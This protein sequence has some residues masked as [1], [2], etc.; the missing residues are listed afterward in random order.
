MGWNWLTAL[1]LWGC[2]P[3]RAPADAP[4]VLL[5]TVDT[6]RA[7]HVGAYG[8][9]LALTPNLD[10]LSAGGS[11]FLR[12][13][14]SSPLTIPSH[15]TIFTGRY[16][17]GHGVRD[18]GGFALSDDQVTLAERFHDAGYHTA[19]VTS[20]F[21]TRSRWG[22]GQ[23]FATYHEPTSAAEGGAD[24]RRADEVVDDA[25][26]LVAT[27]DPSRPMFLWVHL[28]DP[29]FPYDPPEQ[30]QRRLP[31]RPYDAEVAFVDAEIGRL[32]VG[33]ESRF[34][35][36]SSVVAVTA[37]NGE[38]LGEGG[39]KTH[40]ILL[41]DAT[42]RVPLL[43]RGP[44]MV[45]GQR[46]HD[47]VGLV[48][49]APTLLDLAGIG[50]HDG[51]E[52]LDL[53]LGGSVGVYAESLAAT[54]NLGL[55]PLFA[56]TLHN[57]RLVSG[58]WTGF[59]PAFGDVI[60]PTPNRVD[61][62][63]KDARS[64]VRRM[65][66]LEIGY[67]TD[68]ALD[69]Q[70]LAMLSALGYVGGEA[71]AEAVPTDPR[72]VVDLMPLTGRARRMIDI[73]MHL[74]ARELLDQLEQRMPGAYG[75][76]LM[77]AQLLYREGRLAEADRAFRRLY[78]THASIT[79][80]L[81]L[82]SV[83]VARGRWLEADDWYQ[84]ALFLD[85]TCAEALAGRARCA[86]ILGDWT[87]AFQLYGQLVSEMPNDP[88]TA[89]IGAELALR[90]LPPGAA[91]LDA[92]LAVRAMPWS[93]WA[94]AVRGRVLWDLGYAEEAVDELQEALRLDPYP[95]PIRIELISCL[96]EMQRDAEAV[97]VSAPLAR[98]LADHPAAQE[99]YRL[100]RESLSEKEWSI[101]RRERA[102]DAFRNAPRGRAPAAPKV[103]GAGQGQ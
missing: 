98:M 53:R 38:S 19:A 8:D 68:V 13:Y 76:E 49:L 37:P 78:T 95:A 7:D 88:Q 51:M 93:A 75:V 60:A 57:G 44:G 47:P 52:G 26:A 80:A 27:S 32:L 87:G 17:P 73:G 2:G 74:R 67:A 83:A 20:A 64:L 79:M 94:H 55:A 102:K 86:Y 42:L 24:Q 9:A 14:S 91:A 59:Y 12:A 41:S 35:A 31:G 34:G 6:L 5:V 66:K 23:G 84:E 50:S 56:E 40:G 15:A 18:N 63:G 25:L 101:V 69:P 48:D 77:E 97:R 22:F 61:P 82:A 92:E 43:V 72:D 54:Y 81:Q 36:D 100:A 29:Y 30:W 4:S 65:S 96:L 46:S 103:E 1:C 89:L 33:W 70:T 39:E 99:V 11:T 85:P 71:V 28:F 16:P 90:D 3:P 21:L 10:R 45:A 62:S 58:T